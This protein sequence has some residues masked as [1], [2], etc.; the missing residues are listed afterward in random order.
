MN[1]PLEIQSLAKLLLAK[2]RAGRNSGDV[3]PI[4]PITGKQIVSDYFVRYQS[5]ICD[6]NVREAV[7]C[8]RVNGEPIGSNADGYYYCTSE[9]EWNETRSRLLGRIKNQRAAADAPSLR[10]AQENNLNLLESEK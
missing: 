10:F 8:L 6:V 2:L 9:H 3:T 7:H 1:T 5:E 4:H